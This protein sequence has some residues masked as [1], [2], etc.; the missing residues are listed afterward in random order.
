M[1]LV[2]RG[3]QGGM[4]VV[5]LSQQ[6]VQNRI[7]LRIP[8]EELACK[9]AASRLTPEDLDQLDEHARLIDEVDAD[10]RFHERIWQSSGNPLL[11]ET[12]RRV[13]APLF[14]SVQAIRRAGLQSIGHRVRAHR[15]LVEAIRSRD[16]VR[17]EFV[18]EEHIRGGYDL[19]RRR[20]PLD[21]RSL[22]FAAASVPSVETP[23]VSM[24][25]SF[26][27]WV[28]AIVL[29]RD[30]QSKLR[31]A[32]NEFERFTRS[33]RENL[34]G[35]G[36][37][38]Q[39]PMLASQIVA[40]EREVRA[41]SC[42]VLSTEHVWGSSRITLRFPM[43]VGEESMTG[44][45]SFDL[46]ML[47]AAAQ[48]ASSKAAAELDHPFAA[49]HV[50][51][52]LDVDE[53][54]LTAFFQTLPAIATWKDLKGRMLWANC[55]YE[56]VTGKKRD[57][58]V[59]KLPTENWPGSG[60]N[61]ILSH[62]AQVRTIQLPILTIDKYSA[63]EGEITRANIRFPLFD[64]SHQLEKTASLGLDPSWI[65]EARELA[66]SLA[67]DHLVYRPLRTLS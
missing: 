7:E 32:N 14:V 51:S 29:I 48:I 18:V 10:R 35:S 15:L 25:R 39:L 42:P 34:I 49:Y 24:Q 26:L 17:I 31:Y 9:L 65:E 54:L 66:R 6:D 63:A 59:G 5:N 38:N 22:H 52:S 56:S 36:P 16:P 28:P 4:A 47:A 46:Q 58:V 43:Q 33:P 20:G 11:L 1:G 41:K 55:S 57:D 44:T 21:M 37:E 67:P 62:D 12:L 23:A 64:E 3:P 45:I 40:L 50:T 13:C 27:R 60:G 61:A 30:A 19:F 8:L 53:A 2:E